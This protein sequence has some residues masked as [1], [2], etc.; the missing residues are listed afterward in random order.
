M[1]L[2]SPQINKTAEDVSHAVEAG[3]E[4]VDSGFAPDTQSTREQVDLLQRQLARLDERARGRE[5]ALDTTLT[6]LESF[7][8]IHVAVVRDIT[9]VW[10]QAKRFKPVATEVEAIRSQQEE[11][12]DFHRVNIEGLTVQVEE[13]NKT[14]QGLIQSAAAGVNTSSLEKDLEKMNDKWNELKEKVSHNYF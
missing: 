13:C 1:S 9:D 4:L 6:R 7:Y 2:L 3:E 8:E 12:R 11:Y 14:G 5:E 10:E